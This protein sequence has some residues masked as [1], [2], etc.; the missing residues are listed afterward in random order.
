[1]QELDASPPAV[2]LVEHGDLHPGTAA[3]EVDS[4][5]TLARFGR[6]RAFLGE[7]YVPSGRID[8]FTVHLRKDA[9]SSE[10]SPP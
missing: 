4:A 9:G 6:L 7:R 8:R 3:S 10:A 5:T 2:I 1:M